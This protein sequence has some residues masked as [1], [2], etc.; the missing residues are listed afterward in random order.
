MKKN[1]SELS[2][3]IYLLK[4]VAILSV[5]TAHTNVSADNFTM[6]IFNYFGVVGVGLFFILSGYLFYYDKSDLKS[7]F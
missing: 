6:Y 4:A 1:N 7:F 2:N 3:S 5:V